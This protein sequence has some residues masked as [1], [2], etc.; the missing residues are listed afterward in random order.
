MPG[1]PAPE[2]PAW[3]AIIAIDLIG[4]I[5][6][7][8]G[9]YLLFDPQPPLLPASADLAPYTYVFLLAGLLLV[10]WAVNLLLKRVRWQQQ[11]P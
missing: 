3:A 11:S 4:T 7:A 5:L 2:P 10:G 6:L 1:A 9:I 8:A